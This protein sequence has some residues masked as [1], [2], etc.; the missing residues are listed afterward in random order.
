M[1]KYAIYDSGA[2]KYTRTISQLVFSNFTYI[3]KKVVLN[4]SDFDVC[5]VEVM[6]NI[7]DEIE[8]YLYF[9]CDGFAESTN[10]HHYET[11]ILNALEELKKAHVESGDLNE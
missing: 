7:D 8:D 6:N 5:V 10:Y 9:N 4:G 11:H 2:V 3:M 1:N